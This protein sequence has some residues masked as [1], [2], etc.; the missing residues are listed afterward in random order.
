[1]HADVRRCLL[2]MLAGTALAQ[3]P[4]DVAAGKRLFQAQC[5]RCHGQEGS[6]GEGPSLARP[7]LMHAKDDVALVTLI[8]TGIEGTEMPGNFILSDHEIS[9]LAPYVRSL[10]K[11]APVPVPGDT[12]RGKQLYAKAN[13]GTCHMVRGQGGSLGP[14]LS[15]A[16]VRRSP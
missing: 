6:G 7:V 5:A 11:I 9:Q 1:M 13:C 15:D 8:R 16:G 3:T 12:G 2:L 4:G 10:G 14:D